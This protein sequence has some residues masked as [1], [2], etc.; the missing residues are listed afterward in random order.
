LTYN[1]TAYFGF[2][3]D[4]HV[5]PDLRRLETLLKLSIAELRK[6]AGVRSSP[7]EEKKKEKRVRAKA[8][9]ASTQAPAS[10][11]ASVPLR[12]LA[13]AESAIVPE[14]ADTEKKVLGRLIA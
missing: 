3:G 4:V 8:R 1:N 2:S 6:A 7:K 9:V 10:A 11:P 5:A 13:S 12:P 14:P